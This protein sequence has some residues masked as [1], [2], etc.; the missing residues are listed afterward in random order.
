MKTLSVFINVAALLICLTPSSSAYE[1]IPFRNGGRIEGVVV[2][3]GTVVPKDKTYTISSDTKYCGTEIRTGKYL[4]NSAGRIQNVVVYL[5]DIRAGKAVPEEPVTIVDSKCTFVPHVRIG[6]KGNK[7]IITN[8]DPVLHTSHIYSYI[9]G[10]T[11]FNVALPDRGSAIEKTLTKT[12]LM[13]LNCDCHPWMDG[14]VYIFDHPY[15]TITDADGAF[16]IDDVPPGTYTVEAWHESLG[17][18]EIADVSV[19]SGKTV[20][21][22][23][24]FAESKK[25]RK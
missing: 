10:K 13:E 19:Q 14:F 11:M 5:K 15:V 9:R 6:F 12:G 1:S 24:K 7:F 17:I 3:S 2:F 8:E 23:L 21:L 16:A 4:I 18:T 22:R 25:S 20:T